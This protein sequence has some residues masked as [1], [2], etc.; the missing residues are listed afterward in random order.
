MGQTQSEQY[1]I[2]CKG[3]KS[4]RAIVAS[5]IKLP[6]TRSLARLLFALAGRIRLNFKQFSFRSSSIFLQNDVIDFIVPNHEGYEQHALTVSVPSTVIVKRNLCLR[7]LIN[8]P[9]RER[10]RDLILLPLL[11]CPRSL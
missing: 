11:S 4:R 1:E 6:K 9:E 7:I 5:R 3:I 8:T 2:N 10:E